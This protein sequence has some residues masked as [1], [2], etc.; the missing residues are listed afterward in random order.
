VVVRP[1]R[2]IEISFTPVDTQGGF[3][4]SPGVKGLAV[5]DATYL[6]AAGRR[7]RRSGVESTYS[8][9]TVVSVLPGGNDGR[10]LLD[11][12]VTYGDACTRPRLTP[13]CP[14]Y[15]VGDEG[16]TCGEECRDLIS[17]Y[18]VPDRA[19]RQV[20]VG[21]LVLRGRALPLRSAAGADDYDARQRF[22]QERHLPL[23][24]QGTGTLLLTLRAMLCL[25]SPRAGRALGAWSA[26]AERGLPVERVVVGGF[27]PQVARQVAIFAAAPELVRLDLLPA[28]WSGVAA[29]R[30]TERSHAGW[31]DVLAASVESMNASGRAHTAASEWFSLLVE[32]G[33]QRDAQADAETGRGAEQGQ[34]RY[35]EMFTRILG[36]DLLLTAL[37][38]LFLAR[39][40]E[41]LA[42]L[43]H[44]DLRG[45]VGQKAPPPSLFLALPAVPRLCREE[46]GR[47][48]WERFTVTR[49]EDWSESSLTRECANQRDGD[50]TMPPRLL[51][52][53]QVD[54]GVLAQ[55]TLDRVASRRPRGLPSRGLDAN[56]FVGSAVQYMRRTQW[57]AAAE[58]FA[59]LCE[60][61]PA[62]GEALNNLGFCLLPID[63]E[64]GLLKLQEAS[65]Y[66]RDHPVINV[67]NRALALHLL[68]RDGDAVAL[69]GAALA[70][71]PEPEAP[72]ILWRHTPGRP[73]EL[74]E[75]VEPVTHLRQLVAHASTGSCDGTRQ[76]R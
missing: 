69:G 56:E 54:P 67:V 7:L 4:P 12:L 8:G 42:R 75:D 26:L 64:Q 63:V 53:R 29:Q 38:P 47:W 55:I 48:L 57:R 25:P 34:E 33:G 31:A 40:E 65:L 6:D 21:G 44:E 59:G 14:Y 46:V 76:A 23:L 2:C 18:G 27:L 11:A 60:L 66:P 17:R 36:S 30:L 5:V 41:W 68:G 32:P 74:A 1:T 51:A 45:L 10:I 61:R 37:Q 16:P 22:L 62:D 9:S 28:E 43:L 20:A 24:R 39:V 58:V 73:L 19:V 71:A 72:A 15:R 70:G 50:T 35:G 3:R 13:S 52:E 49:L